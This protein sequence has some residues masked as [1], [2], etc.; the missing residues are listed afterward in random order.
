MKTTLLLKR[1]GR[2]SVLFSFVLFSHL[3]DA[4]QA[5]SV[6]TGAT[7]HWAGPQPT[8]TSPTVLTSITI[9][10]LDYSELVV[11]DGYEMTQVGPNGHGANAIRTNGTPT[12][13]GSNSAGWNDSALA[14]FQNFNLN[15]YFQSDVNGLNICGDSTAQSTTLAQKQSLLYSQG[16]LSTP[17]AIVAVVERNANNCFYVELTGTPVGGG[18][19]TILGG[20]FVR[21]NSTLFGANFAPPDSNVDYWQS[22]R[23]NDNTNS[24]GD[25]ATIGI[26]MFYLSDIAPLNSIVRKVT[27][28][29]ATADHGDGKFFVASIAADLGINKVIDNNTPVVGSNVTFTLTASNGNG[30]EIYAD[31]GAIVEDVLPAG[32]TFVSSNATQG[33]YDSTTGQWRIGNLNPG[34]TETLTITATVNPTGSYVNATSIY[35]ALYDNNLSNNRD[36]AIAYPP[37]PD[38]DFNVTYVN[39]P[40]PGDVSTNDENF[41][42]GTTYGTPTAVAGNPDT[43]MPV[44][45][46][47]GTYTFVSPVPGVFQFLVPVCA[48]G[49]VMPNCQETLL[50][51]TVLDETTITNPPVANIDIASTEVNTPVTLNTLANDRAGDIDTELDPTS[52]TIIDSP[53][54]GTVTVNPTTGETTYT[55]NEG[56]IG[57]DT[58]EYQVCDDATPA[59]CATAYQI[60]DVVGDDASNTTVAAD[61]YDAT[62]LNTPTSGNVSENDNDP[63]GDNQTV[64]PQTTTIPGKGTLVLDSTGAYTFTPFNNYVGPVEFP[65]ETCDDGTPVACAKATLHIL[66]APNF[67]LAIDGLTVLG[68]TINGQNIISWNTE[69]E[70]NNNHFELFHGSGLD[71][72]KK[73]VTI[74]SKGNDK[75][76]Q[77]YEYIH[78]TPNK[79][80]NYYQLRAVDYQN[81]SKSYNVINLYIGS[82]GSIVVYPNPATALIKIS[83]TEVEFEFAEISI[84]DLSGRVLLNSH[85]DVVNNT[86]T[87]EVSLSGFAKGMYV[88][89]ITDE[90]GNKRTYKINKQ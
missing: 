46:A 53:S 69:N 52:V 30:S 19:D 87:K 39:V 25:G 40:V 2:L 33:I 50:T 49:V 42:V 65:Y 66:V 90:T 6:R 62:P 12:T 35:G 29:A 77:A 41:P 74:E 3:A 36:T 11:P 18:A 8:V 31:T 63:Q 34:Q 76:Q 58:L 45:N 15:Q 60:I 24:A 27:L 80:N 37:K 64:V 78:I 1:I 47:D 81:V 23:T 13:T 88:L 38:P 4:Q 67:P 5:L 28:T 7:F 72:L 14:A 55:P 83:M 86:F 85:H 79:G 43:S 54:N 22:G 84:T 71:N 9:N 48:P 17:G 20:T 21:N 57:T 59:K 10:G 44:I 56:F 61:D 82:E 51:I 16:I 70:I 75:G 68:Q 73:I 32:F 89:T 26:A